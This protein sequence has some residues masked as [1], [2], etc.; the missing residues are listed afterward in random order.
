M[1]RY[2]LT[3]LFFL[4]LVWTSDSWGVSATVAESCEKQKIHGMQSCR[5]KTNGLSFFSCRDHVKQDHDLCI[6]G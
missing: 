5:E 3:T 2:R 1:A 6:K 4:N